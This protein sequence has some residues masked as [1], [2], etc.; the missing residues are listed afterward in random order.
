[1]GSVFAGRMI[2]DEALYS[3][4]GVGEDVAPP[5]CKQT[6][7]HDGTISN[8]PRNRVS[9]TQR[10]QGPRGPRDQRPRDQRTEGPAD[11]ETRNL[12]NLLNPMLAAPSKKKTWTHEELH[13]ASIKLLLATPR[14]T[15]QVATVLN[16]GGWYWTTTSR[17]Y[18]T[19]RFKWMCS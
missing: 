10:T 5:I 12:A 19:Y 6:A 4:A 17:K 11:Q 1:M 2:L 3:C 14:P 13:H 15:P 16:S 8:R 7:W 18:C 9:K